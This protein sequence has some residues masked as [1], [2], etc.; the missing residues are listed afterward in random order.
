[1]TEILIPLFIQ[2]RSDRRDEEEKSFE[3]WL[4]LVIPD[5]YGYRNEIM[6]LEGFKVEEREQISWREVGSI[7]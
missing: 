3:H 5:Q 4:N 7:P 2:S 6:D 1:M